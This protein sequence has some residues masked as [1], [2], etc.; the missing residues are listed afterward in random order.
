MEKLTRSV[1]LQ[2]EKQKVYRLERKIDPDRWISS[3]DVMYVGESTDGKELRITK[4]GEYDLTTPMLEVGE[5]FFL[6]DLNQKVVI[7]ERMRDSNGFI[8]YFVQDKLVETDE[9][10]VS[11]DRARKELADYNSEMMRYEDLKDEFNAYKES[12]PYKHR[13]FN[14]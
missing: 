1:F 14:L 6:A 2:R 3:D 8:T 4:L 13:F 9:T 10:L 7:T 12:H 11:Y 5:S